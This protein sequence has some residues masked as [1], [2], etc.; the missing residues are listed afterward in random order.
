MRWTKPTFKFLWSKTR[1]DF[2]TDYRISQ[3]QA[4]QW[5]SPLVTHTATQCEAKSQAAVSAYA[6]SYARLRFTV[7]RYGRPWFVAFDKT[8]AI[9]IVAAIKRRGDDASYY[10]GTERP[11]KRSYEHGARVVL[12]TVKKSPDGLYSASSTHV[13]YWGEGG[14][15]DKPEKYLIERY[16]NGMWMQVSAWNKRYLAES[17]KRRGDRIRVI[18]GESVN[19]ATLEIIV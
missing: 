2:E 12:P 9:R 11:S 7:E 17:A 6:T 16:R 3:G 5:L 14:L 19:Y 10:E 8:N 13:H 15:P 1:F 4:C 18:G